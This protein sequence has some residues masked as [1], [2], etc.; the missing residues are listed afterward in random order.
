MLR[1]TIALAALALLVSI[2]RGDEFSGQ[3]V[4]QDAEGSASGTGNV[5]INGKLLDAEQVA[6][7]EEAYGFE[8]APGDYWYDAVSGLYGAVGYQAFGFMYPGHEFGTLNREASRGDTGVYVNGRELPQMEWL[9]WSYMLGYPIQV[10]AYWLDAQG[11]AGYE[12][13]PI[14]TVNLFV[15]AQQNAYSGQGGSG[16]NFWSTRFSA[17]NSNVDNTQGYVSVPGYGPVG[18]GF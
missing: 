4:D 6:Q 5:I 9:I 3:F 2:A 11:N 7:L 12:G 16:D 13:N 8:P 1:S 15:A 14:P 17:G 18:Y 10:G